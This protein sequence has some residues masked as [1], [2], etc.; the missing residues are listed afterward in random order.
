MANIGTVVIELDADVA[1][2]VDGVRRSTDRMTRLQRATLDTENTI[3]N[4]IQAFA[5][6]Y[7]V[8]QGIDIAKD[9]MKSFLDTA[10]EFE[11]YDNRMSA[12]TTSLEENNSEM[13]RAKEF[14]LD[15]KREIDKTTEALLL[16]KN[17][18][19][20]DSTEQLKIYTNTAIGGGK[21]I[22][23]FAE[24]MA[25]ALTGENERLKEFGV[26]ASM[27]G[28]EI[29]YAWSDSS[30]KVRN[31]TIKNNKD[32]ID[33]TLSAIFNEKYVGQL[34]AYEGSWAGTIQG[35]DNKWTNFK[36]QLADEG[37][38]DYANAL[39]NTLQSNLS[40]AIF[41]VDGDAKSL[42]NTIIE[43]VEWSIQSIGSL[44]DAYN[45][46]N[47]VLEIVKNTGIE[48]FLAMNESMDY[49][50]VA[51]MNGSINI[52]N[53][54]GTS[55]TALKQIW[56]DVINF[57]GKAWTDF[58]GDWAKGVNVIANMAGLD[59][60]L[61]IP[62][63]T[64]TVVEDYKKIANIT[65]IT[66]K[67]TAYWKD[68]LAGSDKELKSIYKSVTNEDGT[69]KANKILLE[70]H[71]NLKAINKT[72]KS[73]NKDKDEAKK[74]L[75]ELGAGYGALDDKATKSAKKSK[76]GAKQHSK[77][78]KDALKSEEDYRKGSHD[79]YITYLE[80][81]GREEEASTMKLGD[82]LNE[83][84]KY[85]SQAQLSEIY[86]AE[87]AKMEVKSKGLGE[88]LRDALDI[89]KGGFFD[90]LLG[91]FEK[92]F[93]N[94]FDGVMDD[95]RDGINLNASLA[96]MDLGVQFADGLKDSNNAILSTVGYA[97]DLFGGMLSSTTGKDEYEKNRGIRKSEYQSISNSL[98]NSLNNVMNPQLDATY[99]MV[100]SL[101][102]MEN[103]FGTIAIGISSSTGFDYA[104]G[105]FQPTADFGFAGF[106][107]KT[108]ELLGSGLK[109]YSQSLKDGMESFAVKGYKDIK[110]SSSYFWG[111]VKSVSYDRTFTEVPT[112]LK[113]KFG[114]AL[115]SGYET[116]LTAGTALGLSTGRKVAVDSF[117]G[118]MKQEEGNL[119][120]ALLNAN[121]DI[122]SLDFKGMSNKE[123]SELLSGA[124]GDAL[125]DV[126]QNV[127]P[128]VKEFQ[129]VGEGYLETLTRVSSGYEQASFVLDKMDISVVDF[130]DITN[131]AGNVT[132]ETIRDSLVAY[133][134]MDSGI[135]NIISSFMGSAEELL[136]IYDKLQDTQSLLR[137][138]SKDYADVTQ[139][140]IDGAGDIDTL[141]SALDSYRTNFLSADEQFFLQRKELSEEFTSLNL[142]LP[143]TAKAY[144]KLLNAQDLT[145]KSGQE[146]YGSLIVLND[147]MKT[148]LDANEERLITINDKYDALSKENEAN[149]ITQ[150]EN[151][152]EFENEKTKIIRD[153]QDAILSSFSSLKQE[154]QKFLDSLAGGAKT[155]EMSYKFY[156]QR[157]NSLKSEM[158]NFVDEN[159][160]VKTGIDYT[161]FQDT[162]SSLQTVANNLKDSS[163]F[164]PLID[165]NTSIVSDMNKYLDIFTKN[166]DV[167]KVIIA[168]DELGL[169]RDEKVGD[170]NTIL[171]D[172]KT[173]S[174]AGNLTSNDINSSI[175]ELMGISRELDKIT[176]LDDESGLGQDATFVS[177]GNAIVSFNNSMITSNENIKN[178][179]L[180]ITN[181]SEQS[182]TLDTQRQDEIENATQEPLNLTKWVR[183]V[184][185]PTPT[186]DNWQQDFGN[187]ISKM[188][189]IQ[190]GQIKYFADGGIVSRP[191]LGM[192]AEAGYP[193]AIIP[194]RNG[195]DI[196]VSINNSALEKKF[197][198]LIHI[199]I[200]Q[201]Q[202]IQKMRK[203]IQDLNERSA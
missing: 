192:V 180:E 67:E 93:G 33:S 197:D 116:I 160:T 163:A 42:N 154:T 189:Q 50:V 40:E 195:R 25:D 177:L 175:L 202:E 46:V 198:D 78:L 109:S 115:A 71:N 136:G 1:R 100:S 8:Q 85:L 121:I 108:T 102:N 182:L 104:G 89:K 51:F 150:I 37:L 27:V 56:Y 65:A 187:G 38:L 147:G 164:N 110:T 170:L 44:Y 119:K 79:A 172:V 144:M 53:A 188:G 83:L 62:T 185:V 105:S 173:L 60:K 128:E 111:L 159:G 28:D 18:G 176:I 73:T 69:K 194:M 57:W 31:I 156:A 106:S 126:A 47:L 24:A 12:F 45:G 196:P 122:G 152:I 178:A 58:Y 155:D 184:S 158:S 4:F 132:A 49:W 124:F 34:E 90:E 139:S 55:A 23:Q 114:N 97:L 141:Q 81:T 63:F 131:K 86:D 82:K 125:S 134:T 87:M 143:E 186:V 95:F 29:S 203:E 140:M 94:T 142:S 74:K 30:G 96:S 146:L 15:Y 5:G 130:I 201:A 129:N 190:T 117:W 148:F 91:S 20:R 72:E 17:N 138:L 84:G 13:A 14:A 39:A 32:I 21:S 88:V 107:S 7:V 193:E 36:L 169:A 112:E 92:G 10:S 61:E 174:D 6:M 64:P 191:T 2:L 68:Q 123:I 179:L 59:I 200:Q 48:T 151:L 183:P 137:S 43:G 35:I 145:T 9:S 161:E 3:K 181:A 120:D 103:I 135:G 52:Q 162:F 166:E 101:Q 19:L 133:E 157:Y 75:D 127:L 77:A 168:G 54:W 99:Q 80:L 118:I 11:Q 26:K 70:L 16:M 22:D 98:A 41:G 66:S 113:E 199:T 149:F 171:E 76:A 153:S 165:V 167:M